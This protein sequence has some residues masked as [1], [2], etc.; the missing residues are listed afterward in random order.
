MRHLPGPSLILLA[1]LFVS[2]AGHAALGFGLSRLGV[3]P[4]TDSAPDQQPGALIADQNIPKKRPPLEAHQQERELRLGIDDGS[5]ATL[6]W[7]GFR[8]PSEHQARRGPTEQS[9]L[10]LSQG[11][12]G[13]PSSEGFPPHAPP[14]PPRL[15]D[16]EPV[17]ADEHPT[18]LAEAE[19]A[20]RAPQELA[21]GEQG[22]PEAP[23]EPIPIELAERLAAGTAEM[24]ERVAQTVEQLLA[25][26]PSRTAITTPREQLAP[27]PS[28]PN[29]PQPSPPAAVTPGAGGSPGILADRESIATSIR[30]APV[31]RPGRVLAAKGLEILTRRPRFN[32][33]TRMT[34]TPK[35][36]VVEITFGRDG[37]VRRAGFVSDGAKTYNTGSEEIDQPLLNAIYAWTARGKPLSDIDPDDPEAGVT[38]MITIILAG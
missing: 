7:L 9:G 23:P 12:P 31:V 26:R 4:S 19:P 32:V 35:N 21:L 33:S 17:A 22:T 37:R 20:E 38:I 14:A 28:A 6:T 1:G 11:L 5:A 8:D 13:Q 15:A 3:G 2:L 30:E 27:P 25:P 10:T 34:Q 24:A 16:A 29:P 18:P 36:A